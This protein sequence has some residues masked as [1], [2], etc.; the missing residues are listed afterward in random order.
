[1]P[2]LM[3]IHGRNDHSDRGVVTD[4]HKFSCEG[5]R[6]S[7]YRRSSAPST[8]IMISS[9]EYRGTINVQVFSLSPSPSFSSTLNGSLGTLHPLSLS[10]AMPT[11]I[12]LPFGPQNSALTSIIVYDNTKPFRVVLNIDY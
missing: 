2:N 12:I 10:Q 3:F 1:M 5:E 7:F 6:F 8:R 11:P 9:R 4:A